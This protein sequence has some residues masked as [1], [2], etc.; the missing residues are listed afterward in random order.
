[1]QLSHDTSMTLRTIADLMN[2][3]LEDMSRED[4]R[5]ALDGIVD[6]APFSGIVT[7][8]ELELL[9]VQRVRCRFAEMWDAD[10]DRA[11]TLVNETLAHARALPQL[12]RHD[13]LDW[14]IHAL[15]GSRPL[16][17]RMLVE[18]ALG[19]SDLIRTN[20]T[21]RCKRCAADGCGNAF[22]DESRNRSRRFCSL[23][24]QNRTN[25]AAF[26]A[27]ARAVDEAVAEV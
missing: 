5:R 26:R 3:P 22:F 12:V 18:S 8:D 9:E 24:C 4:G 7:R 2:L 13:G 10:R 17:E 20:E 16:A 15:D 14:H 21:A 19:I 1:M 25:V 11:A 23:T 27:R 6:S